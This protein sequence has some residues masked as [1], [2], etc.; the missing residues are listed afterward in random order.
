MSLLSHHEHEAAAW[1]LLP[2]LFAY[3]YDDRCHGRTIADGLLATT[4]PRPK[5]ETD[6][7]SRR[8]ICGAGLCEER[9][10]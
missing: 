6:T 3:L 5:K 7:G 4:L 10:V 8:G 2:E 9:S 1:P